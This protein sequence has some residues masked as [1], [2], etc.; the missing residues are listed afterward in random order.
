MKSV[1]QLLLSILFVLAVIAIGSADS[2]AEAIAPWSR[3]GAHPEFYSQR[4]REH[5]VSFTAVHRDDSMTLAQVQSMSPSDRDSYRQYKVEL[6]SLP[7]LFGPLTHRS[8]AAPQKTWTVTIQWDQVKAT[9]NGGVEIPFTYNGKWLIEKRFESQTS[10]SIPFVYNEEGLFTPDW[11]KCSD[12][13]PDHQTMDFFWYFWDPARSGCDHQ[14]NVQFQTINVAIGAETPNLA[15][16]YPEYSRMLRADGD[17]QAIHTTLGFGY[18]EDPADPNPETDSDPGMDGYRQT[19]QTVRSQWHG[20]LTET[21]ILQGEYRNAPAPQKVI[22]HRF[23]GQINGLTT[24]VAVVVAAGIDQME[25]FAKSFAHD[26]DGY[27]AWLG[28][29]RVGSG[30]DADRFGQMLIQDPAYFSITQDYQLIYWGGCNSYSYYTLPFFDYKAKASGGADPLGT[31]NLDI[32]GNGFPSYFS[33]NSFNSVTTLKHVLD[34]THPASYQTIVGELEA[35]ASR[36][37]ADVMVTILGDE[38]NPAM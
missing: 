23:T 32:L 6:K 27:F 19:L 28:H 18:F 21:P 35:Q 24:T 36:S 4:G 38:D 22:G 37:G 5:L 31:K 1:Y 16:T 12:S 14:L 34:W 26:H 8:I 9:A 2:R 7:Y 13:A 29:S 11:K 25:V 30:F 33:L 3:T 20:I 17:H 15:L 10:F